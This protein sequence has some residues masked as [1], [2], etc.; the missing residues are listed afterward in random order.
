MSL[1]VVNSAE[2]ERVP[3]GKEFCPYEGDF[4]DVKEFRV[5][6]GTKIHDVEPP[7]R[8]TDGVVVE[9]KDGK[10]T[11]HQKPPRPPSFKATE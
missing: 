2:G 9:L 10:L 4:F 3:R 1:T 5:V 6:A 11:V 8:A 7:H